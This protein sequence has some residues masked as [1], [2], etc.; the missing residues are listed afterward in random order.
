MPPRRRERLGV[1]SRP[2]RDAVVERLEGVRHQ[3]H[4]QVLDPLAEPVRAPPGEVAHLDEVAEGERRDRVGV[5]LPRRLV[6]GERRR[7][8]GV[9]AE[10]VEERLAVL[11]ARV[12]ALPVEGDDRVRRV[13]EER[14]PSAAGPRSAAHRDE[15]ADGIADEVLLE[16]RHQRHRVGI[17]AAEVLPRL[18]GGRDLGEGGGPLPR[19]EERAG[20]GAV[21]V[22]KRDHHRAAARPDVERRRVH[23]PRGVGTGA[24]GDGRDVELLV[25]VPEVLLRV[26][27]PLGPLHG[28]ADRGVRAVGR[29]DEV[30][31][32]VLA[33]PAGRLEL[34]AAAGE[35]AVDGAAVEADL[36]ERLALGGVEEQAVEPAAAHRVDRPRRVGAVG[37]EEGA[38]RDRMDH[39]PGHPHALGEHRL[40]EP[41]AA[42]RLESPR[43]DREVDRPPT[44][45]SRL[46]RVRTA[47]A[48]GDLPAVAGEVD[49]EQ[50][51]GEPRADDERASSGAGAAA[52]LAAARAQWKPPTTSTAWAPRSAGPRIS[53]S[54]QASRKEL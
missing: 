31:L 33:R 6:G 20:E 36:D 10:R 32:L 4:E 38:A 22:G 41:G 34:D 11:E 40:L 3:P 26:V 5:L 29:D 37:R 14:D 12:R 49:R 8:L 1:G 46:A 50:A 25:A 43:R 53:T 54:R 48:E 35:V 9:P 19:P 15:G 39:A 42:E 45:R 28:A 17:D 24:R 16:G 47:L 13:A 30:R 52:C 27:E 18:R 51:P 23:R 44:A 21:A 2:E 7:H